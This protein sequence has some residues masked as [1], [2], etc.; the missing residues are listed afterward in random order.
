[1][2]FDLK[3]NK[4][5]LVI[6]QGQIQIV[7]DSEKLIQDILKICLTESG[8]NS[9]NL[10][11]GSLLSRTVVGNPNYSSTLV[12]IAKTQLNTC[13]ET[14]KSLQTTQIKSYQ[15]MTADEQL[16]AIIELSVIKNQLDPRLFSI[17][18]KALNKGYKPITTAFKVSTI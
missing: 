11:Y 18:I 3:I 2:S 9:F 15:K 17:V 12:Q 13:L 14:L 5:D 7:V 16:G 1:M 10:W 8:A 6:T 4:G